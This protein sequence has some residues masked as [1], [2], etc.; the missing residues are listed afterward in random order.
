MYSNGVSLNASSYQNV[1]SSS[2]GTVVVPVKPSAVV[3]SQLDHV[4]GVASKHG[5]GVPLTKVH[6]LNTLIGQLESMK[7]KPAV[8]GDDLV[9]LSDDQKDE[10]IKMYQEEVQTSIANAKNYG[11]AGLLPESG[12]VIS[13]SA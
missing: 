9:G 1:F 13:I 4:H 7:K 3:Y 2:A 12:T 8:T 6:I 5:S 10:L 11:F